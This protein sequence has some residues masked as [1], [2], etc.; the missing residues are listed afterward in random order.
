MNMWCI[1]SGRENF[2][3]TPTEKLM[4][5]WLLISLA[6]LLGA[7]HSEATGGI[8]QLDTSTPNPI[9]NDI[10]DVEDGTAEIM[11]EITEEVSTPDITPVENDVVDV[12]TL[13]VSPVPDTVEP[14]CDTAET[15]DDDNACTV[16]TCVEGFCT[17]EEVVCEHSGMYCIPE[18]EGTVLQSGC[19]EC[20]EHTDC[21]DGDLWTVDS[22]TDLGVCYNPQVTLSLDV[23]DP[24][25]GIVHVWYGRGG[26][27][28]RGYTGSSYDFPLGK[29]DACGYQVEIAVEDIE[30][31][32]HYWGC[33]EGMPSKTILELTID[34]EP[35]VGYFAADLGEEVP[36]GQCDGWGEG[37]LILLPEQLTGC[38]Q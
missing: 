7:C 10:V 31:P 6:L 8:R 35:V 17:N 37:N 25:P 2:F 20:T 30:F 26:I 15:C 1:K 19:V 13:D 28:Q 4:P 16:D 38:E 34:G 21:D 29:H 24:R 27:H 12:E 9:M 23:N 5:T 3:T 36:T 14:E 32:G 22:C 33:N 18:A 11:E